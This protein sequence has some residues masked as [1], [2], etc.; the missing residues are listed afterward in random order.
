MENRL[1]D[2]G[3]III[4]TLIVFAVLYPLG[5]AIGWYELGR[6][7]AGEYQL[8]CKL[9]PEGYKL[10]SKDQVIAREGKTWYFVAGSSRACKVLK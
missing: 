3:V 7:Q 1:K 8:V 9:E 10:I 4:I 5:K 6:V 2:L